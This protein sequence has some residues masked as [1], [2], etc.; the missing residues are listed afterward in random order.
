MT[1]AD[2]ADQVPEGGPLAPVLDAVRGGGWATLP[3]DLSGVRDKAAFL[4]RCA[5]ALTLPDWFGRN[6]D[7]LADCLSDLSWAPGE[8]G[9]LLVVSGWREYADQAPGDWGVAQD[10]FADAVAYWRGREQGL[11]VV[12]VVEPPTG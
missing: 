5:T 6:W 3:L 2:S 1:T 9:R 4:D 11:E 10:V 7:A 8:R 12:L